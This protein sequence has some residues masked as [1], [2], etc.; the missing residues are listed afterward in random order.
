[1]PG[2]T[3]QMPRAQACGSWLTPSGFLPFGIA[4]RR[5][6]G[7]PAGGFGVAKI[8]F[9]LIGVDDSDNEGLTLWE[10]TNPAAIARTATDLYGSRAATAAAYCALTAHFDGRQDDYRF[11][12]TVFAQLSVVPHA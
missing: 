1:M 12:C 5:L 8:H 10:L 11:W 7:P 2:T 6:A 9:D 3:R 4:A